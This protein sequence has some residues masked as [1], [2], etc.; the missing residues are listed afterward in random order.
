M[1]ARLRYTLLGLGGLLIAL[2]VGWL[3][4][5]LVK[6]VVA[7][8]VIVMLAAVFGGLALLGR[9]SGLRWFSIAA[10]VVFATWLVVSFLAPNVVA[11]IE[12]AW[13]FTAIGAHRAK[14]DQDFRQGRSLAPLTLEGRIDV[15]G[16]CKAIER[17]ETNFLKQELDQLLELRKAGTFSEADRAR[18][19]KAFLRLRDITAQSILC[20]EQ[21]R[22]AENLVATKARATPP[23]SKPGDGTLKV[24]SIGFP[25]TA[26]QWVLVI[27][28]LFFAAAV[29]SGVAAEEQK[30]SKAL[31]RAAWTLFVIVLAGWIIFFSGFTT[32]KEA[33]SGPLSAMTPSGQPAASEAARRLAVNVKGE[34]WVSI[35]DD[36]PSCTRVT[37]DSRLAKNPKVLFDDGGDEEL[38]YGREF[39]KQDPSGRDPRGRDPVA[40]N[41]DGVI[42]AWLTSIAKKCN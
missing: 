12:A 30:L 32:V 17:V 33:V 11:R 7:V 13:Q 4:L 37:F 5:A 39:G 3:L 26:Y 36:I 1:S 19:A 15:G 31:W 22:E 40:L 8:S 2:V 23:P 20:E 9:V 24:P 25:T 35:R 6:F 16:Y 41:G 34:N 10:S 42:F 28:G 38:G 21:I 29:I 27:A 14:V 18:E